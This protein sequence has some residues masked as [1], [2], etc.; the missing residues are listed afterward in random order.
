MQWLGRANYTPKQGNEQYNVMLAPLVVRAQL[1]TMST[2]GT[3]RMKLSVV[4]K[5]SSQSF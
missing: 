2:S 1:G 3:D 5:H 4:N